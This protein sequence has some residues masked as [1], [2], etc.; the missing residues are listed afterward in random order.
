MIEGLLR[1]GP[2]IAPNVA[3]HA[4][5]SPVRVDFGPVDLVVSAGGRIAVLAGHREYAFVISEHRAVELAAELQILL[6]ELVC[7]RLAG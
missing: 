5:N 2:V 7:R 6:A 3:D 1:Q 4:R